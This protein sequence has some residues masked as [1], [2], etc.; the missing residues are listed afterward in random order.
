M[1]NISQVFQ[2]DA[3]SV[4]EFLGHNGQGLY[5]PAYQRPYAWDDTNVKR[6]LDDIAHGA[7]IL[8]KNPDMALTFIGTIITLNDIKL[9]TINPI[10][11][12]QLFAKVL[13]IIDGQQRLTT[14]LI[15]FTAAHDLIRHHLDRFIKKS[16]AARNNPDAAD[17]MKQRA[18]QILGRL[19]STL[20]EKQTAGEDAVFSNF[21]RMIRA[22]DDQWSYVPA[23]AKYKSPVSWLLCQYITHLTNGNGARFKL[24]KPT[25][26]DG[27]FQE[28][29]L[30]VRK[31]VQLVAKFFSELP[32]NDEFLSIP[33]LCNNRSIQETLFQDAFPDAISEALLGSEEEDLKNLVTLIAFV[34]FALDR[35]TLVIVTAT[36]E[37]FAFDVFEALNTTGQPLTAFET[38]RPRVVSAEG[39]GNYESSPS[40]GDMNSVS[41]YLDSIRKTDQRHRETSELVVSYA[42]AE[43]GERLSKH[44]SEQRAYLRDHYERQP[45]I[46]LKRA[47]VRHLADSALF[48]QHAWPAS[49]RPSLFPAGAQTTDDIAL[50]LSFLASLGHSITIPILIRYYSAVRHCAIEER[51][52]IISEFE[53]AIKAV[54]AFSIFWRSSRRTT[55]NIDSLYRDIM[56][57]GVEGYCAPLARIKENT[58]VPAASLVAGL[59]HELISG[60]GKI[61]GKMQWIKDANS[62]PIYEVNADIT[63]MLLLA[64]LDDSV[65]DSANP[66]LIVRGKIGCHPMLSYD[67]WSK[68]SH[69]TIE[70]V[71]PQSGNGSWNSNIYENKEVVHRIGN[72]A[73]L[74]IDAN[75]SISDRPPSEKSVLYKALAQTT[76]ADAQAIL[77]AARGTFVVSDEANFIHKATYLP[78]LSA[79]AS[80][81]NSWDAKI[82]Q[83][84][85]EN[86]LSLAWDK[87]APWLGS[88]QIP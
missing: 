68:S 8:H 38:F 63:R 66:G 88:E 9:A 48:M 36:T 18:K 46:H 13:N 83:A 7:K 32:S 69:K 14:L 2:P 60:K 81:T 21:P 5:I 52:K 20:F 28:Q 58:L 47:A 57:K 55:A 39:L 51:T 53:M 50:C 34:A 27:A 59:R 37:D 6:M 12:G 33:E 70:H 49:E 74:P 42:L 35:V 84:R 40:H 45:N 24:P 85:G 29:Y 15:L 75:S 10:V 72:L 30:R 77:D 56:T 31:L 78:H 16:P 71:A 44:L 64:A 62:I 86:L 87:L 43:S 41:N 67:G 65:E 26:A 22:F 73:L 61:G 76:P 54:T 25:A 79:V 3:K 23:K 19:Q 82:I 17:W 1:P 80:V 4:F 11:R